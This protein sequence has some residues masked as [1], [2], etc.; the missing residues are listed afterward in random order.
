MNPSPFKDRAVAELF[1]K[2][3]LRAGVPPAKIPG[4]YF[5]AFKENQLTGEEIRSLFF[6]SAITGYIFYPQQYWMNYNQNGDFTWRGPSTVGGAS[7]D[8]GKSRIEGNMICWQYQKRFWGVEYCGT[9][10]RYPG[11]S[12]EG[13]DEYFWCTDFGFSTFS[14]EK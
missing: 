10:F 1:A 4:G 3:L 5:P 2:G 9:I 8:S 14:L 7:S 6:G 13:K 12:Y 11:G